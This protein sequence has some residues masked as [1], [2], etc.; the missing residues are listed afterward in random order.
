MSIC[1]G[2][3]TLA[4][5]LVVSSTAFAQPAQTQP[6]EWT[7]STEQKVFGLMTVWAQARY[8]FPHFDRMP[9]LDWDAEA[10]EF[11]PRVLAAEDLESYYG[12][13]LEFVALLR[14]SHTFIV[15]PWGHLKP[16]YDL[17]P[18]EVRVL[19]DRF[20]VDRV[21]DAG[22]LAA[23]G[24]VP[25]VEI[26]EVDGTPVGRA[27]ADNVLR[28]YS[29]GS[30]QA[31]EA[32][33]TVYLLY[34]PAGTR[35]AL[36][37]RDPAGGI[38]HASVTRD[39]MSGEGPPFMTRMLT[40][41]FASPT[42]R[43]EVL[44]DGIRYVEIPSFEHDQVRED[45]ERL[46]DGLDESVRG[47]IIDLR[48]NMG[49]SSTVSEPIVGCLIDDAVPSPTMKYRHFVGAYEAWG[50]EPLWETTRTTIA[51]RDGKRYLGPLVILT[52]GLTHSS[53]EDFAIELRAAGRATLVGQR[54]AG[55]AGNTLESTLPGGGTLQVA[56]FTALTPD[57]EDYVGKGIAPDVVV[58]PT[59]E[60]LAAGRD[61]VLARAVELIADR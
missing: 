51:P 5:L 28:Y 10:R 2:R 11:I 31:D 33:L 23:Q 17:A 58:Q 15:P 47:M 26:L 50:R 45:F 54:T 29:K 61:P 6:D 35:T 13:L 32:M 43:T 24:V 14:D 46:V 52:G 36:K 19:N 37:V 40:N 53:A 48:Y 4:S 56:T 34:G 1:A 7:G 16:G 9:E 18:I 3:L 42:I 59:P 39:A 55:G 25:G 20:W 12:V 44:R 21:G 49:G 41:L 57:G 38:H 30:K 60:D 8:T 27:F 22:A